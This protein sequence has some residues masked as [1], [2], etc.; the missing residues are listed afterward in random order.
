MFGAHIGI[1]SLDQSALQAGKKHLAGNESIRLLRL[2]SHY[3][4]FVQAFYIIGF[5][6]DTE[7]SIRN[8]I[9]LL[10]TLDID[11]VQ[12]QVLT[13][14]PRTGQTQTI[15]EKYGIR[16]ANLSK[17]NSRNL[18]WNHPNIS[19]EKMRELQLWANAR[20]RSPVK[21][22]RTISKQLFHDGRRGL[23]L[24][25]ALKVAALAYQTRGLKRQLANNLIGAKKWAG[26]PW[27][28][29]EEYEVSTSSK[30]LSIPCKT[31]S[32]EGIDGGSYL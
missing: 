23:H 27:Y 9:N 1:E 20:L 6:T 24:S 26:I 7:E 17:Y 4:M 28:A 13:P 22:I 10:S 3:N 15:K 31:I 8:D 30:E 16:D 11:L 32:T 5:E 14:Y 18:V 19:P 12:V 21:T 25:G 2:M 29:Y